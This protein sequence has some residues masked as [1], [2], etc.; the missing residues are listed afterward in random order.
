M[1]SVKPRR[2]GLRDPRQ[3][4]A[5]TLTVVWLIAAWHQ[6]T[7]LYFLIPLVSVAV[8]VTVEAAWHGLRRRRLRLNFSAVITGLL[9][10]LL[11]D[12]MT[13]PLITVALTA[14]LA[15]VIKLTVRPRERTLFNPAALGLMLAALAGGAITSWWGVAWSPWLGLFALASLWDVLVSLRLWPA[16]ASFVV[17]YFAYLTAMTS[18]QSWHLVFDGTV[19]TFAA[20]MLPEPRS[21]PQGY[22]WPWQLGYSALVVIIIALLG[23]SSRI[24]VDPLLLALIMGALILRLAKYSQRFYAA[25][26]AKTSPEPGG[27]F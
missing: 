1:I 18:W 27:R 7:P 20:I 6:G 10:G 22:A 19:L 12:P 11:L 8:A 3:R 14:V 25:A 5:V 24:S 16:V 17:L 2:F 26:R 21:G 9:I 4:V 13:T 15:I 23:L